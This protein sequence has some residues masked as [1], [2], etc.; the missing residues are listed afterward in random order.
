MYYHIVIYCIKMIAYIF[1]K[2]SLKTKGSITLTDV[3]VS[4]GIN[5]IL[6]YVITTLGDINYSLFFNYIIF[7]DL[8]MQTIFIGIYTKI[9]ENKNEESLNNASKFNRQIS[10]KQKPLQVEVKYP[11]MKIIAVLCFFPYYLLLL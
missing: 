11:D 5:S 9:L 4:L 7:I 6:Y 8:L 3:G 2:S 10:E 1:L